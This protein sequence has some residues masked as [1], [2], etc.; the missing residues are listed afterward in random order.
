VILFSGIFLFIFIFSWMKMKSSGVLLVLFSFSYYYI[1]H[2]AG[3][4]LLPFASIDSEVINSVLGFESIL[5]F[6]VV[7]W[8]YF[9]SKLPLY[10]G[11]LEF[12]WLKYSR[13]LIFTVV[14]FTFFLLIL[15]TQDINWIVD[16]RKA[17]QYSRSGNGIF[18]V[19]FLF[20]IAILLV[21]VYASDSRYRL[22]WLGLILVLSFF[23]GSKGIVFSFILSV[24]I[25]LV[26]RVRGVGLIL[27]YVPSA[28]L[29]SLLF[30]LLLYM[31]YFGRNFDDILF[32]LDA[33]R[34]SVSYY[35]EFIQPYG[36]RLSIYPDSNT[37]S[38]V[39]NKI[40]DL[41]G[42]GGR[43]SFHEVYFPIET[44]LGHYAAH[45][46]STYLLAT[47][48]SPIFWPVLVLFTESA[49]VLKLAIFFKMARDYSSIRKN[50]AFIFVI[51]LIYQ[52]YLK[53]VS[54]FLILM[55]VSVSIIRLIGRSGRG[56]YSEGRLKL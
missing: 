56:Q 51:I 55:L 13:L 47:G 36:D 24:M 7:L 1:L 50:T 40:L 22:I 30:G 12:S 17:Y 52:P 43:R 9:I 39:L 3:Y 45:L 10:W 37:K 34:N 29:G 42:Y 23:T 25:I 27:I 5:L 8:A 20:S 38:L 19:I 16:P 54:D 44:G 4:Y 15:M 31:G 21:R 48:L 2:I 33:V 53:F 41:I 18:Y 26:M 49:F 46:S 11:F 6:S 32:H 35:V 28:I 14:V